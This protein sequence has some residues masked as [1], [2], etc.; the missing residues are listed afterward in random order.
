MKALIT[1][2]STGIGR[3]M[4]LYMSK[5]GYDLYV[6]ARDNDKLNT[7]KDEVN[8]KVYVYAYD[9]SNIDNCYKLYDSLKDEEIDIIINNAGFG[10]YGKFSDDILDKEM[11][12][13][14]LNIK[15]LHILTKL[16][17]NNKYTKRT[18]GVLLV[19]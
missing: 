18:K 7:L 10:V 14:D 12:M 2:A 8:T 5:L 13:I 16:F 4:A 19:L 3:E 11:N 17:L 9:L 6:V 15:C 1:G